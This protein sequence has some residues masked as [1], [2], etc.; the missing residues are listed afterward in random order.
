MSNAIRYWT[1]DNAKWAMIGNTAVQPDVYTKDWVW[2]YYQ[3]DTKRWWLAKFRIDTKYYHYY[4]GWKFERHEGFGITNRNYIDYVVFAT[5]IW[6][7]F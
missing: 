6:I 3:Y 7:I 1:P 5:L 4:L 2:G